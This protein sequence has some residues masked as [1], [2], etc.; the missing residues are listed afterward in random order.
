[1]HVRVCICIVC[2]HVCVRERVGGCVSVCIVCVTEREREKEG[3]RQREKERVK[4]RETHTH[5]H[6]YRSMHDVNERER[7][8]Y[9]DP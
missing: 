5:L 6:V 2:P 1:V 8:M 9:T 4:E 7:Y 3:G